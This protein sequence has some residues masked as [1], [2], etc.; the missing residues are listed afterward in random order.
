MHLAQRSAR[1]SRRSCLISA[2]TFTVALTLGGSVCRAAC[3]SGRGRLQH[4]AARPASCE[5]RERR[6]AFHLPQN[7]LLSLA[8]PG[9]DCVPSLLRRRWK[10]RRRPSG[11][12]SPTQ[13]LPRTSLGCP[14]LSSAH[15]RILSPSCILM[16]KKCIWEATE[17]LLDDCM[18]VDFELIKTV[19]G[20]AAEFHKS[21]HLSARIVSNLRLPMIQ[22]SFRQVTARHAP[23]I[24]RQPQN[25]REGEFYRGYARKGGPCPQLRA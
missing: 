10:G 24:R 4:Q 18:A 14:S 21:P 17:I 20:S 25:A 11:K 8:L 22:V 9:E 5:P 19:G 7:R 13:G 15:T 23:G 3:C 2:R 1:P 16:L 12:R 6:K